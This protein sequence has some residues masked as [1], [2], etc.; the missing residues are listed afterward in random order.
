MQLVQPSSSEIQK[1]I[2]EKHDIPFK[3]KSNSEPTWV[4]REDRKRKKTG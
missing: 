4:E 3:L 2:A 1:F